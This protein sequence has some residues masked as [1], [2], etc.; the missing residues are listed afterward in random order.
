M[1]EMDCTCFQPPAP[2]LKRK[3]TSSGAR[4]LNGRFNPIL[5]S[6]PAENTWFPPNPVVEPNTM[7]D[8]GRSRMTHWL[9]PS[10]EPSSSKTV[11]N[12]LFVAHLP[13]RQRDGRLQSVR[14]SQRPTL[15]GSCRSLFIAERVWQVSHLLQRY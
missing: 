7:T 12:H 10:E 11:R 4:S 6:H 1:R 9:A 15:V 2:S 3:N 5:P 8:R 13:E 14:R